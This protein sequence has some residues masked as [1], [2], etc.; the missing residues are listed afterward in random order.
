MSLARPFQR[1]AIVNRGEPAM[2]LIHA[3]RELN[4]AR[5]QP[6][7]TLALYTDP[8]RDAMF[9]READEAYRLGPAT[10]VDADGRR[11]S[12]YLDQDALQ[13]ALVAARADAVWVGWGFVSEDPEFA[14]LCERLGIVFVGPDAEAMRRLGD[15]VEAKRL[16]ERAGV[17]VAPWSGG[18]VSEL[19]D[20]LE[21]AARIGFPLVIKPAAGGGGRGIRRVDSIENLSSAFESARAEAREAFGHA[22]VLL[23]RLI[24]PARQVEVEVIADGQGAVWALGVRDCSVQR[25]HKKVI[26]E[27]ASPALSSE[28]N[29]Q[30]REAGA[31]L[32]REAGYRGACT[33]EFL[34]HT[35]TGAF[36]FM[37]V[38]TRLQAGHPVTEVT[39]GVDL[40][41][42]QLHVA[43]GGRLEGEMPSARGH[44]VE[45]RLNAEDPA[46]DFASAP[47][48]VELLRL[49]TGPGVRIDTGVGEGDV[50]PA[51]FDS[52]I[53]KIIAWGGDR[54]EALTR[55][56]RALSETTVVIDGGTTNQAFLLELLGRGELLA[57]DID[58]G[59]LDG[60]QV[61]GETIPARHGEVAVLAAAIELA[62]EA[63]ADDR[64]RFFAFARRG[65]PQI[66]TE[67]SR[68]IEVR[69]RG[70]R[71]RVVVN[72]IGPSSYRLEVEKVIVEVGVQRLG[73]YERRLQIGDRFHRTVISAQ[74]TEL[75]VEVDGVSHRVAR[76]D[77]GIVRSR[78]P[79]VV[80]AIPVAPGDVVAAG[81]VVAV[82]ESMK[83]ESSYVAPFR[84]R[85]REVMTA[86]NVH[87][88]AQAPIVRIEPLDSA[89]PA[90][91]G[92]WLEF[93]RLH[94]APLAAP[95]RCRDNLGRLERLALGYDVEPVEVRRIVADL[96]GECSDMLAC[97]PALIPGEHRLLGIYADLRA[98]THP[99]RELSEPEED[100]LRSPQEHLYEYLRS[101]DARAEGLPAQF[102]VR[103]MR[104]LGHY[105]VTGLERSSALEDAC[106]RLFL[107][108]QRDP[109]T[110]GA[111][112]AV[113]DRR[114]EQA[115]DLVGYVG[116]DFRDALTRLIEATEGRDQMLADLA[117]ET[118]FRYFDEPLITASH[119][120]TY[121]EME[122]LLDALGQEARAEDLERSIVT[123]VD[124]PLP[125]APLLSRR[126]TTAPASLRRP[127]LEVML[128][129]YYRTREL[130]GF[131]EIEVD[132]QRILTASYERAG[133]THHVLTA[134]VE[135]SDLAAAARSCAA[136][137][138][139]LPEHEPVMVDLYSEHIEP[140][141]AQLAPALRQTL[142][143]VAFPVATERIVVGVAAPARGRGMS[144]VDL[145][146]F[147][148]GPGGLIEDDPLRGLHPTMGERLML[149]RLE[150][151]ALERISSGEDVYLFHGVARENPRDERLFALAEVR[152]LTPVRGGDG[153]VVAL[154][155][156]ERML[157]EGL[158]AIRTVQSHRPPS[159]RLYWNRLFLYVWP[160]IDLSPEEITELIGRLTPATVGLGLEMLLVNGR[161][162]EPDRQVR[163]RLLRIFGA[164]GETV[165][166]VDDQPERPIE[167]LD[168]GARRIIAARR[169]G[170]PH[171]IEIVRRLTS[172]HDGEFTEYD[173][174]EDGRLGPVQRPAAMNTGGVVAGL[175]R[176]RTARYPEGMARIT[177]LGDPTHALGS[178]S[179]PE[180]RRIIAAIELADRA[181]LPIDWFALSAGAKI[182]MDSGTE[183]MDWIS[184]VLRRIIEFTQAG[185]EINIVV[186][187]INVGAQPYFNAEATMLMHTRGILV[188]TPASAMV[189][190]GK[191]ALDYS[192]VVSAEDNFGIG[193]YERIMGPN[194]QAQYWAHD[195]AAACRILLEH[196]EHTYVAPG[197]RFPRRA[198]SSDPRDRDVSD[199]P[200]SAPGSPL[201]RVGDVFSAET[202]PGHKQ[203]FDIR[204][205]MRAA[206]DAD[207]A[208]LE[209]W[210]DMRGAKTAVVWDAHLGGWPVTLL[211]LESRPLSRHGFIPAD[212]PELWTSGTLFP[213]S[214]KKVAR[215]INAASGRVPVVVL[216]NL[217]GFDG[218]PESMRGC[219][220]EFG[221][222]IGRSV[223]NFDGPIV[224][225]V[226]SRIHGGA[227]V[228]FSQRLND[229]LET[230]ALEGTHASVIGGAPAAGVV[231]AREVEQ[232]AREDQRIVDL[233][234]RIEAA[235]GVARQQLRA[236][237]SALFADVVAEKRGEFAAQFD[238]THSV[239]R[240]VRM[241]SVRRTIAPEALRPYL[242]DAVERGIRTTI[243]RAAT[244]ERPPA[245]DGNARTRAKTPGSSA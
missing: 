179:E 144:A 239:Q 78:A 178:L 5:Q 123:L 37:E 38:K 206:I 101:L 64:A 63:T 62:D 20:A 219:E 159:R 225:C 229:Q 112:I 212:G 171:P 234:A 81:D 142:D 136:H 70:S 237:R 241:G 193:G 187:G 104:A 189:L 24:S 169:R 119:E 165:L 2:R 240:A 216:A 118:R 99:Q 110:R 145:F 221:A 48:R 40:V 188:M 168:E 155:E 11:R 200:H 116:E 160:E 204:S 1:L 95:G 146:T 53:A 197:E 29:R 173:L 143:A 69:H 97:D 210:P 89:K 76:D 33:V 3:V 148:H 30:L 174:D 21:H 111:M 223:V 135:L 156:F 242:I 9:A 109:A 6:I 190:T 72:Q 28:Q 130:R 96:H 154:P 181:E 26:E 137:A 238:A 161:F 236:D 127:L 51:E 183:T 100:L 103:L 85:V 65:R 244:I 61:R 172:G 233:D 86:A 177:L 10:I 138:T 228:V 147:R 132:R 196:H 56:R 209:R 220:L 98:L 46:S 153:R 231:F 214:A 36:S 157:I 39:T 224:F 152:D 102:V 113:L 140:A 13:R 199:S 83:M 133:R 175:M 141:A 120:Q 59:W 170:A 67:R 42:L 87:L 41:K 90:S 213:R 60:L 129:R 93:T 75:L 134:F 163:P 211:G 22:T 105:G 23:E 58:T 166:E 115:A 151:F 50:I 215:A 226:I 158:E 121:A 125:L 82:V 218:S 79:A 31:R 45:A 167:P 114:L 191:Q 124:C 150:R 232:A 18:G 203:P 185:G 186:T 57:G 122:L 176:N 180:C 195:L 35:P 66:E 106:Y 16:A 235:D 149:W 15:K 162:R 198:A 243:E 222:E 17:T 4:G 43:A 107:S 92:G 12:G 74:G 128:R 201:Q 126:L 194:G 217:A 73:R 192:G 184:A 27:S 71:H 131:E 245:S 108:D 52:M 77:G 25:C 14:E 55:L 88:G 117:R 80:V 8:E 182:A 94:T 32:A 54:A 84:G 208:P 230:V 47:G 49:P 205:V 164:G 202:N 44:S 7:V 91:A 139:L 68:T 19:E 34:C 227:F 207:H